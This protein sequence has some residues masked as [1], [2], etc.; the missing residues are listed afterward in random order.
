MRV[1]HLKEFAI[2][3]RSFAA[4]SHGRHFFLDDF[5]T[6]YSTLDH[7]RRIPAQSLKIDRSFV[8]D[9]L[10]NSEDRILTKRRSDSVALRPEGNC[11]GRET[12]ELRWLRA[13][14]CDEMQGFLF[15]RPMDS[16]AFSELAAAVPPEHRLV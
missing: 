14:G 1:P 9:L 3:R 7:L 6:G 13:A 8:N 2:F 11:R 16:T 15:A 5:G 10:S 4:A 12:E